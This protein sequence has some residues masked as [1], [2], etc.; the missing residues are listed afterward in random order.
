MTVR[1]G[2]CALIIDFDFYFF[3]MASGD[4]GAIEKSSYSYLVKTLDLE[5]TEILE[6]ALDKD[7]AR[8]EL[9]AEKRLF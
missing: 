3:N 1:I 9:E 4:I 8:R 7:L 5:I 2:E 6:E